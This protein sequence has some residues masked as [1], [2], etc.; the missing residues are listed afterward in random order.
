MVRL[1]AGR[2]RVLLAS[3][4]PWIFRGALQTAEP[5]AEPGRVVP[6]CSADGAVFAWGFLSESSLIAVRVVHYGVEAPREG[7]L[8]ERI[9]SALELRAALHISADAFR[10]INGEGDWLPGLIVDLYAGTVA[11][12]P[13]VRG[14]EA[15]VERVSAALASHLPGRAVYLKRDERAARL[16]AL[17][18]PA[19][20]LNGSGDGMARIREGD[21]SFWVDIPQGQK[22]GYY[23]DQRENR[24]L[25]G[26]LAAGRSVLNLFAYT[27]AFSLFAA[28]GGAVR[29]DSVES[30]Q[31][32]LELARRNAALNPEVQEERLAWIQADVFEYLRECPAYDL[33][34]CDPPPFA[35]RKSELAGALRGYRRLNEWVL[36]RLRPGG[37][38]MTFSCSG[39]VSAELFLQTLREAAGKADRRLQLLQALQAGPDHPSV[40]VHPEGE[41]LKGWLLR[42]L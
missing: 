2:D 13:L 4:H 10:L 5:P 3:H 35:R 14:M 8:E 25:A 28:R 23:L 42:A 1:K 27:G 33:I 34:V 16:E 20:Y 21:L 32:A 40:L 18:L 12:R 6:V 9:A 22:T 39:A 36:R 37:L 7:W 15:L 26:T 29:V 24:A 11:I 30:S 19:G 38:C 17:E 41:Y 31:A